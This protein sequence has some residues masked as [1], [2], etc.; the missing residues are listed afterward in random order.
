[1]ILCLYTIRTR[2]VIGTKW[3]T[4]S[5]NVFR[6][7]PLIAVVISN[8]VIPTIIIPAI[9][10]PTIIIPA[11]VIQ[12]IITSTVKDMRHRLGRHQHQHQASKI[13]YHRLHFSVA[14][15]VRLI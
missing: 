8:K 7:P 14:E 15:R 12:T 5:G 11:I 6:F 4:T 10:I 13:K 9:V 1:M 2:G 3:G